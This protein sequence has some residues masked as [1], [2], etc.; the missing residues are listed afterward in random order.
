MDNKYFKSLPTEL[1]WKIWGFVDPDYME[2]LRIQERRPSDDILYETYKLIHR[3]QVQ[4]VGYELMIR[5]TL[6]SKSL[7]GCNRCS[8]S[9]A[10]CSDCSSPPRWVFPMFKRN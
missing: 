2:A 8:G 1:I 7:H 4:D 6:L 9:G 3:E 5:N 10:R